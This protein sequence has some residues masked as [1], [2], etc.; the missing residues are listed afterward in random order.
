VIVAQ[1]EV[2]EVHNTPP[3]DLLRP[4]SWDTSARPQP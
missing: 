1:G 3:F 4:F 2:T